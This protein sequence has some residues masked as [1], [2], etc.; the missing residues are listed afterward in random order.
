LAA[1]IILLKKVIPIVAAIRIKI[2]TTWLKSSVIISNALSG[3]F[4]IKKISVP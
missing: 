3:A 4:L 2:K 1:F